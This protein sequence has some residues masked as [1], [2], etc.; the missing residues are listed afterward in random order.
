MLISVEGIE[1]FRNVHQIRMF[2]NEPFI[3]IQIDN[4]RNISWVKVPKKL[5]YIRALISVHLESINPGDIYIYIVRI[6]KTFITI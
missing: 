2:V 6:S 5:N 4:F 3:R 1:P